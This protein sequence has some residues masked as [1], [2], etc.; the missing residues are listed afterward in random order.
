MQMALRHWD[1]ERLQAEEE[2]RCAERER[3]LAHIVAMM[4]W[5]DISIEE[6]SQTLAEAAPG[7]DGAPVPLW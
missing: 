1:R 4:R 2:L 5:H 7:V 3:A 6:V